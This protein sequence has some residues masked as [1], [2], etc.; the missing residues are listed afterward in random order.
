MFNSVFK[1][2]YADCPIIVISLWLLPVREEQ[3]IVSGSSDILME[4]EHLQVEI[5]EC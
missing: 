3:H 2:L 4:L 1:A 5:E